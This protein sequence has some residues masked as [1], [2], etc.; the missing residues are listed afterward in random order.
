MLYDN[1]TGKCTGAL[2]ISDSGLD[3]TKSLTLDV[4]DRMLNQQVSAVATI[5]IDNTGPT[6]TAYV[7]PTVNQYYKNG[8]NV[9]VIVNVTDAGAGIT[10]GTNCSPTILNTSIIAGTVLYNNVTGACT[11]NLTIVDG[12]ADG[13]K[14]LFLTVKDALNTSTISSYQQINIDNTPP[15]VGT[16][17]ITP[18]SG[19]YISGSSTIT[20]AITENGS[21]VSTCEY[22]L[23]NGTAWTVGAYNGTTGNCTFTG[24]NTTNASL[25]N[26]RANDSVSSGIG[27]PISV[28]PD[29]TAPAYAFNLPIDNTYYKNGSTVIVSANITE[30]GSGIANG[31][32]C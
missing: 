14:Q 29:V 31:T 10:N 30:T 11:G 24:V 8:M 26:I 4:P 19:V 5:I 16:V 21:G 6:Y 9:S 18:K 12:G 3:G 13:P 20:A 15:V 25:I 27:T 22:T 2:T 1:V 23:N 7:S 32:Y 17:A 28:T